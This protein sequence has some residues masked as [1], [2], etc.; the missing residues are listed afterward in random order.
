MVVDNTAEELTSAGWVLLWWNFSSYVVSVLLKYT[1]WNIFALCIRAHTKS[2]KSLKKEAK[3]AAKAAKKEGR[4]TVNVCLYLSIWIIKMIQCGNNIMSG[5]WDVILN[6][7]CCGYISCNKV[8]VNDHVTFF[9][10]QLCWLFNHSCQIMS[11]QC[12]VSCMSDQLLNHCLLVQFVTLLLLFAD[13]C[14]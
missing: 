8:L 5:F 13:M 9:K 11:P 7:A 1:D 6:V 4:E 14:L 12:G 3:G 2:K 10:I